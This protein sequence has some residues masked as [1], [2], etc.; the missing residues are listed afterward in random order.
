M[1]AF[2]QLK[3]LDPLRTAMLAKPAEVPVTELIA[4]YTGVISNLLDSARLLDVVDGDTSQGRQVVALDAVVHANEGFSTILA[5]LAVARRSPDAIAAYV[6]GLAALQP[7]IQRFVAY[8]TPEQVQLYTRAS[9]AVDARLGNGFAASMI[10]SPGTALTKLADPPDFAAI[11]SLTGIGRFIE[12]KIINDALAEAEASARLEVIHAL[13]FVGAA[14]IAMLLALVL[15]GAVA[16]SVTNP[17]R[18]LTRSAERVA[19]LAESELIR[20]ADDESAEAAP[21]RLRTDRGHRPRRDRRPSPGRSAGSRRPPPSW[22]SGRSPAAATSPSCS[23]TSVDAPRTWSA[24]R[25]RLIDKLESRGD[26]PDPA[27]ASSTGST[28]SPAA[29]AA[30]RAAWSCSPA[31][32]ASTSTSPR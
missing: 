26:R 28:T 5:A 11:E 6:G 3:Q 17:V 4:A 7:A 20:V 16:R 8:A 15:G 30:T 29:C 18:R 27:A 14:V 9:T 31:P 23:A 13:G 2:E 19:R 22:S 1:A 10:Q 25:S 21:V 32:P 24:A 12:S